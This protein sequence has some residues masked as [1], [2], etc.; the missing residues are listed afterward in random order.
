M[1]WNTERVIIFQ[2][3]IL[4]RAQGVNNSSKIRK[5]ILF[6]LNWWNYGAFDELVKDTYICNMGY[7]GEAR[8]SQTAEEN[9]R[10]FSNLVLKVKLCEDVWLVCDRE[11]VGILKP[12]ELAEIRT[13]KINDTIVSIFGGKHPIK[14]ITSC[15][16]LETYGETH[17]FIPIKIVED[18][19]ES[20]AL[21]TP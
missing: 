5:R 21:V 18:A 19:V 7:L 6:W 20:V 12:Y 11:N 15:A 17:I 2:S 13:G 9:H 14:T 8:G 4:Q 16:T 1:K 10:T 3:I